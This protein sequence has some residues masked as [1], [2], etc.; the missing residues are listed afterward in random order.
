M[1]LLLETLKLENG[2]LQN[3]PY[4]NQRY[5]KA[6]QDLFSLHWQD[7]SERITIPENC[8]NG[9]FRCRVLYAETIEKVEFIPWQARSIRSLQLVYDD[10]ISYSHKFADRSRLE[11]LYSQ[12]GTADE[13]IIV[14]QGLVTDSFIAN[15]VF[16]DG[17][18]WFTP[19]QPLLQGTQRQKL[20]DEGQIHE[21]IITDNELFEYQKIGLINVFYNLYN[22]PVLEIS[23]IKKASIR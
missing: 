22:M 11:S 1:S 21:A 9:I 8:R 18:K 3:L 17:E 14:K 10:Q 19:A 16:F 5:N 12:R 13:I 23:Q 4:H 15:L 6:R 7:L 20:L 2:K